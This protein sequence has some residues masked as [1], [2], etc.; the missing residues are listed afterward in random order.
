MEL[1]KLFAEIG[2]YRK[3]DQLK[4]LF[5]F[6]KKFPRIAPYNAMLIHIQKPGSRFVA[7]ASDWKN[8][9]NRNILPG[10]SPLIIL[11]P[12]GPVSFVFELGDT[13]GRYPFP[14]ELLEPFAV[15]GEVQ[16]FLFNKLLSKLICDG[17][18]YNVA[19]HGTSSAGFIQTRAFKREEKIVT[20]KK[21]IWI[22]IL[23]DIVVNAK[24]PR[25]TQFVTVV[26]EL[27]HLY[28]GHLGKP[29]EIWNWWDDRRTLDITR[30]E[31]EAESV[32]WLICERM[33]IKNPSAAYLS[34]YLRNNEE[35]PNISIETVLKAAGMIETLMFGKKE[36]RKE[37]INRVVALKN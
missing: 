2:T 10:A 34:G 24:H 37:I 13:W 36:P 22:E 8:K 17:I 35:I 5:E 7:H 6:V 29:N 16:S 32:C 26:H 11:R 27:A 4:E 23:Y 28:C 14:K 31:F 20:A 21:E 1:D 12:F 9:Y 15:E 3:S 18:A 33:G 19:E 30:R 25:S